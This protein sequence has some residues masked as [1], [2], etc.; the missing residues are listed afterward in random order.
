[1]VRSDD[2]RG[3]FYQ[4]IQTVKR[5]Y[6]WNILDNFATTSY[7]GIILFQT[8]RMESIRVQNW[9]KTIST[10]PTYA[11]VSNS[12]KNWR[13]MSESSGRRIKRALNIDIHSI[14]FCD[15]Q[16]LDRFSK[17]S[18]IADYIRSRQQEIGAYNQHH[19]YDQNLNI[20]GRR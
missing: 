20:D 16:M 17:I 4:P 2:P 5:S 1:M 7:G 11:L 19:N 15:E 13:E 12:F 8:D 6:Y 3:K 9:D 10:I 14:R 18:M